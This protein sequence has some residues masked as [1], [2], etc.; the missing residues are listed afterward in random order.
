MA[1]KSKNK[2]M[3]SPNA[4]MPRESEIDWRAQ[5]DCSTLKSAAEI[6]ADKKRHGAAK[7]HAAREVKHL[8]KIAGGSK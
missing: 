8:V 1:K 4:I 7:A 5:G 3:T 2:L 6:M